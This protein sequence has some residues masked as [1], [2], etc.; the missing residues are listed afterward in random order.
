M[1]KL[2]FSVDDLFFCLHGNPD[3]KNFYY[4]ATLIQTKVTSSSCCVT[5]S[6]LH[7][8]SSSSAPPLPTSASQ[9]GWIC[10]SLHSPPASSLLLQLRL[11]TVPSEGEVMTASPSHHPTAPPPPHLMSLLQPRPSKLMG[12]NLRSPKDL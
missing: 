11:F 7:S 5:S 12:H 9:L 10:K 4:Y 6:S 8:A 1:F 2:L 3:Y